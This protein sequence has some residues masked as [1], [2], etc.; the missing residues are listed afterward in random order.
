M[1]KKRSKKDI[2][3]DR[4]AKST[5]KVIVATCLLIILGS[6]RKSK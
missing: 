6:S 4:Q 5:M 2:P 3:K 1:K